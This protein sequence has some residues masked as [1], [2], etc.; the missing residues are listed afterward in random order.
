L[1]FAHLW[2]AKPVVI[3]DDGIW[4]VYKPSGH[5]GAMGPVKVP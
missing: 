2:E 1:R 5:I 3:S 4:E